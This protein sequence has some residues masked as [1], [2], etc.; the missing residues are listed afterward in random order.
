MLKIV[1][2][3]QSYIIIPVWPEK[4]I[5]NICRVLYSGFARSFTTCRN[6]V[7]YFEV[8]TFCSYY[9]PHNVNTIGLY[10][11]RYDQRDKH[12]GTFLTKYIFCYLFVRFWS[13]FWQE[14][15]VFGDLGGS[16]HKQHERQ[17]QHSTAQHS[18]TAQLSPPSSQ[19]STQL[20]KAARCRLNPEQARSSIIAQQCWR[21]WAASRTGDRAPCLYD[22]RAH[23]HA[24]ASI[25]RHKQKQNNSNNNNGN[26]K[27][28]TAAER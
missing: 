3:T 4:E 2:N 9:Y 14:N 21:R 8:C 18:S 27:Q 10:F 7:I 17:Q 19:R 11:R 26:D 1:W 22:D 23:Q 12:L 16:I 6:Y 13:T 15:N 28:H 24:Q 20:Q 5:L 25:D